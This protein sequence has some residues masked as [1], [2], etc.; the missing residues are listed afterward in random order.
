MRGVFSAIIDVVVAIF[1]KVDE[2]ALYSPSEKYNA[3]LL[4]R[5]DGTVSKVVFEKRPD[6]P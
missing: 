6:V 5:P 2:M 4:Y 1:E 3:T